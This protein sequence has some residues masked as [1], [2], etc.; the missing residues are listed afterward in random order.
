[1]PTTKP[2]LQRLREPE[3]L[4]VLAAPLALQI[5]NALQGQDEAT[6]AELAEQVGR[7][8]EVIYYHLH[9]LVEAGFVREIGRRATARRPVGVYRA[10]AT[11]VKIDASDPKADW[12]EALQ[13]LYRSALRA[14]ERDVRAS[15]AAGHRPGTAPRSDF[16]LMARRLRLDEQGLREM[17]LLF[18]AVIE[19]ALRRATAR[20]G[21]VYSFAVALA[22]VVEKRR[23]KP[24]RAQSRG[25]AATSK[26]KRAPRARDSSRTP[27]IIPGTRRKA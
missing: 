22:P 18:A 21:A 1:M 15:V 23:A 13:H 10:A 20:T 12:P 2:R 7:P 9:R 26:N 5:L 11:D 4:R 17:N 27:A 6:A 14:L 8:R 16:F 3:K 24:G 25:T 19:G